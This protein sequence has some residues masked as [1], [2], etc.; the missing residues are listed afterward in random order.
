MQETIELR[1]PEDLAERYLPSDAGRRIGIAR[2][3]D[4][5]R[6]D[7]LLETIKEI[8]RHLRKKGEGALFTAWDVVRR[9][10]PRELEEAELLHVRPKKTFEPAGEECGTKYDD[11]RACQEC[12]AGAPQIT[13]L[14]LD[15]RQI[16]ATVDFARTIADEI[17]VSSRVVD[18]FDQESLT[19]AEFDPVRLTDRRAAKSRR[20]YQ[21]RIASSPIDLDLSSTRVGEDPFD[22]ET[23]GRCCRGDL[24]GLNLLSEVTVRKGSI[25]NA[26]AMVTKQMIGVRRGL[27][28]PRPIL[29]VS[30]KAWR[31]IIGRKL[32]GLT[33]EVAHVS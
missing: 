33:V 26:D 30:P 2:R 22:E 14:L 27:L 28:R 13:P 19:G 29:L 21:F 12:G 32:K 18:L 3:L 16:P 8:D 31:A 17:V 4:L 10:S 9:Y 23:Y 6:D 5:G 24:V 1:V 7:P 20:H 11:A 25:A 15:G